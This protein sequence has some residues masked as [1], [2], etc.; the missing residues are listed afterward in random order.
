MES[1][2]PFFTAS[3]KEYAVHC[4]FSDVYIYLWFSLLETVDEDRCS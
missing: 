4:S 3:T 1:F 2:H